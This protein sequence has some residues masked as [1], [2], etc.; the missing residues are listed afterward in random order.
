MY[1]IL[2]SMKKILSIF[3]VIIII[4]VGVLFYIN[5][6]ETNKLAGVINEL[7]NKEF[8]VGKRFDIFCTS[9]EWGVFGKDGKVV[10]EHGTSYG[11]T[12][13]KNI[14]GKWE[15]KNG[16]LTIVDE[17]THQSLERNSGFKLLNFSGENYAYSEELGCSKMIVGPDDGSGDMNDGAFRFIEGIK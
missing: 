17:V 14:V 9:G 1:N 16:I 7:P 4:V 11:D 12:S 8:F 15:F 13:R 2:F 10:V 6:Q 3:L 5:Y